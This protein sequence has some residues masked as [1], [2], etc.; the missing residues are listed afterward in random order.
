MSLKER[1]HW[2]KIFRDQ[3]AKL[4][5][6]YYMIASNTLKS[7]MSVRAH[8]MRFRSL[9]LSVELICNLHNISIGT[10]KYMLKAKKKY[11]IA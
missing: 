2:Y 4:G 8:W 6:K 10:I 3:I 5:N 9:Y 11:I 7:V 1:T